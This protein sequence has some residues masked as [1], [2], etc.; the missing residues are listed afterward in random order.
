MQL[1]ESYASLMKKWQ[2]EGW[3]NYYSTKPSM[4]QLQGLLKAILL[5]SVTYNPVLSNL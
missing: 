4:P 3:K 1:D 5:N 2:N